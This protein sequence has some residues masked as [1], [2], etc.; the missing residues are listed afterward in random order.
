MR[1]KSLTNVRPVKDQGCEIIAA[2]TSGAFK[3]SDE[4]ASVLGVTEG[5]R[6]DIAEHPAEPGKFF[7]G[8][9]FDD[10]DNVNGSKL[11]KSGSYLTLS[12]AA[13]WS[14][15]GDADHNI[16]FVIDK[17][18]GEEVEVPGAEGTITYY[19]LVEDRK[20]PKQQRSS[21]S[22]EAANMPEPQAVPSDEAGDS[23]EDL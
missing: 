1:L 14:K 8:K 23:L 13:A 17:E 15:M 19:P 10:G 18:N 5:D 4:A 11:G 3:V 9:G 16:H 22:N 12:A 7:A 20:V 21:S 2:P 6:V